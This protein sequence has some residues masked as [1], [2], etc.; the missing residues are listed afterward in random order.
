MTSLLSELKDRRLRRAVEVVHTLVTS[1]DGGSDFI[2]GALEQL[3]TLVSSELTTLSVCDLKHGTRKVFGRQAEALSPSD[4]AMFDHYFREHPLVRFHGSHPDG[5]TQR[6]TDCVEGRKFKDSPL[7]ADY[8]ARIGISHVM[9]L[10]LQIDEVNVVSIVF[11]RCRTDFAD[12]DRA[13]FEAIR[14]QLSSLYR[15]L[16]A[17]D[18]AAF[19]LDRLRSLAVG[20]GW[21]AMRVTCSGT[22]LDSE[23]SSMRLLHR[24]FADHTATSPSTLPA[25]LV[26]W[27][28]RC[29]NWGL[30][31]NAGNGE[32]FTVSRL[33]TQLT[34]HFVADPA[35][36]SRGYLLMDEEHQVINAD[37][38]A[39][40][41]LTSREREV[42]ALVVAGKS[43][44]DIGLL[45]GISPRTVQKHLE[46]TFLKLGVES[47]T[48]A[49]VMVLS[50]LDSER[51]GV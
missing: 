4:R 7:Y 29:R 27:L 16:T 47:R 2:I 23:P 37:C 49:A 42:L 5:P 24:Y 19:D 46:H 48:A 10:P 38:L 40:L 14:P 21:R 12:A 34:I 51:E 20:K 36:P 18:E 39:S 3:P 25:R 22:I 26:A 45:L 1:S 13:V 33:G 31:R 35:E 17:R 43:N 6:I 15:N 8:Y 11:N 50:A 30:D 28:S 44:P 32:A 9:A 41:P